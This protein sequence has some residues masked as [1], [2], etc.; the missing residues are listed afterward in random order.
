MPP[1]DLGAYLQRHREEQGLTLD[2]VEALSHIRRKYLEAIEAGDWA[3][4]PPGVYTRGLIKKYARCVGASVNSVARLYLKERPQEAKPVEPQLISQPLVE[5][6]RFNPELLLAAA[7]FAIAGVLLV[8]LVKTEFQPLIEAAT[9][10]L[11]EGS[12][13]G[14]TSPATPV[15][16][17]PVTGGARRAPTPTPAATRPGA[18]GVSGGPPVATTRPIRTP[19]ARRPTP[20]A[21]SGLHISVKATGRVWLRILGDGEEAYT[22]FMQVGDEQSWTARENIQVRTGNAGGTRVVINGKELEPLGE[23][24][25]VVTCQWILLPDGAIEQ[26]CS[27]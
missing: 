2:D 24:G 17:T 26:T 11:R 7:G 16:A 20:T 3:R 27:P 4:L 13:P 19:T 1:S 9:T 14:A 10:A 8:W 12:A 18:A 21:I 22:G 25:T 6:P 23:N 5:Q 15:T